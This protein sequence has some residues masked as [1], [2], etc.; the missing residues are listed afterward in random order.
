LGEGRVGQA[1]DILSFFGG[2]YLTGVFR[3]RIH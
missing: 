2:T 3:I 1:T